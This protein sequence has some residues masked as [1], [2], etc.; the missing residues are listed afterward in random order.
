MIF[1]SFSEDSSTYLIFILPTFSMKWPLSFFLES[2]VVLAV[3]YC[4]SQ[5]NNILF[6]LDTIQG[7]LS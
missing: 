5:H 6:V 3:S 7:N 4:F 1:S 2:N